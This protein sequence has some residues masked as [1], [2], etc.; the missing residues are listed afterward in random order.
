MKNEEKSFK[1]FLKRKLSFKLENL[2]K[3]LITGT[4][5]FT[6]T[7][8]GGGGSRNSIK[9]EVSS[10]ITEIKHLVDETENTIHGSEDFIKKIE[11]IKSKVDEEEIEAEKE[12]KELE[13]AYK[14]LEKNKEK[15][16]E[17]N[18]DLSSEEKSKID[19]KMKELKKEIDKKVKELKEKIKKEKENNQDNNTNVSDDEYDIGKKETY[20][21]EDETK[22]KIIVGTITDGE[23]YQNLD[24]ELDDKYKELWE[25][26]E[27]DPND[28]DYEKKKKEQE[29][30][31]EVYNIG[32]LI[33]DK[34]FKTRSKA[35]I[36]I[37]NI[38]IETSYG[39]FAIESDFENLGEI[40]VGDKNKEYT[41]DDQQHG[42][43]IFGIDSNIEN[44]G[45][46]E[47][48]GDDS[49]GIWAGQTKADLGKKVINKGNIKGFKGAGAIEVFN[50]ITA[51]NDGIIES[52]GQWAG[53]LGAD[54]ANLRNNKTITLNGND[55]S[56]I[57]LSADEEDNDLEIGIFKAENY[58]TISVKGINATGMS[59]H[60]DL[61]ENAKQKS[62]LSIENYGTITV[63][64]KNE[65][66]VFG[67]FLGDYD[68][69]IGMVARGKL[70]TATNYGTIN[71][72]DE[73]FGMVAEKGATII[74]A[75]DGVINIKGS[76]YRMVAE[77]GGTAIDEK[78][79]N[80]IKYIEKGTAIKRA[81]MFADKNST[82]KNLGTINIDTE[83][84]VSFSA[85]LVDTNRSGAFGKVNAKKIEM[86][87]DI[88]VS[89]QITKKDYK[90]KYE[91]KNIVKADELK[92]KE[93]LK[94]NTDSI[95]YSAR[96][97]VN[98]NAMTVTL[99][100][101]NKLEDFVSPY[102]KDIAK[103][104]DKAMENQNRAEEVTNIL[105]SIDT[106]NKA[107]IKEAIESIYPSIYSNLAR[108]ISSKNKL[109]SSNEKLAISY[110]NGN[111]F[112]FILLNEYK[113]IKDYNHIN[114]YK[115]NQSGFVGTVDLGNNLYGSIGYAYDDI[116]YKENG[117]SKIHTVHLGLNKNAKVNDIDLNFALSGEYNF[118]KNT[119][120]MKKIN[121]VAKS[122]F[123]SYSI[124]TSVKISQKF[125]DDL[126]IKPFSKIELVYMKHEKF[127][128]KNAGVLN[129][130]FKAQSY[131]SVL[132]QIG[133]RLGKDFANLKL[134]AG[135]TYGYEL[136]NLN[137]AEEFSY[138]HKDLEK[139]TKLVEDDLERERVTAKIGAN[140]QRN[141]FT[142]GL[143]LGQDFDKRE[144][145][146]INFSLG[147]KF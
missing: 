87:G 58:G 101:T 100:K 46:I 2:V 124:G 137:R 86:D 17:E 146:F 38:D 127:S 82:I 30:D 73:G 25:E 88:N 141:N 85:F 33:K 69:T 57:S 6:V 41:E 28:P 92:T 37:K 78:K 10:T 60:L 49:I 108:E 147:Y 96:S 107:K 76:A 131:T 11:K 47:I 112:G 56:G 94:V 62:T 8:C 51:I 74:N 113:N 114:G 3:F 44:S 5:A 4:L 1:G 7:A 143:N 54:N 24:K 55:A 98:N 140:Y 61:K 128:E 79:S 14:E 102:L 120:E 40:A 68:K 103:I 77:K 111:K 117:N 15:F 12:L 29:E 26:E 99:Y 16:E 144:N 90:D 130:K 132:P 123:D 97:I 118:H 64:G 20:E 105:S 93:N 110:L 121:T 52:S 136:G 66:D 53:G 71:V 134:F 19:N 23:I 42:V 31:K 21:V 65:N 80:S 67:N 122:K 104:W 48:I 138:I 72:E 142:L 84:P 139:T 83:I 22:G 18:K 63:D 135:L 145:K 39:V 129:T 81:G 50:G 13:E 89:S 91:L 116:K 125:G 35:N 43:A 34:N 119:R 75:K 70:T 36:N 45:D 32:M 109:F 9:R 95:L 106:S 27:L 59:T 133:F 126:Y 115:T